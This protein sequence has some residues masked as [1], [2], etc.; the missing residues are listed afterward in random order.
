MHR[1]TGAD[2]YRQRWFGHE[3]R[4]GVEVVG[5]G[6]GAAAAPAPNGH[7]GGGIGEEDVTMTDGIDQ[8]DDTQP[9]PPSTARPST[10]IPLDFPTGL[11]R[12][13]TGYTVTRVLEARDVDTSTNTTS[14]TPAPPKPPRK[15]KKGHKGGTTAVLGRS[16]RSKASGVIVSTIHEARTAVTAIGWNPNIQVG[17]WA[18]AGCADGMVVVEDLCWD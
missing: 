4:R 16:L 10:T 11:S 15:P 1:R 17:G 18:A 9:P 5:K 8:R 13:T 7:A 14:T 2:H 3:W 6:G 12:L